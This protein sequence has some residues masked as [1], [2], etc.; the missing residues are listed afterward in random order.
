[1][2]FLLIKISNKYNISYQTRMVSKMFKEGT[3][4]KFEIMQGN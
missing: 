2:K 1:M 4:K 3:Q